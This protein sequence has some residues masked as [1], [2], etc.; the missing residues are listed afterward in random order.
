[1]DVKEETCEADIN[2]VEIM[3]VTVKE[4]DDY[5]WESV[6][7]EQE[8]LGIKD[9]DYEMVT[10]GIEEE[11]DGASVS[12]KTH[13][14]KTPGRVDLKVRSEP[15]TKRTEENSSIGIWED[16]PSPLNDSKITLQVKD[17]FLSSLAQASLQFRSQQT[18]H[19][20]NASLQDNSWPPM[21]RTTVGAITCKLQTHN[22]DSATVHQEQVK[23][24][25]GKSKSRNVN[26]SQTQQKVYQCSECGKQFTTSNGLQYHKR[27]H[28]G[29]KAY[30][31]S[32]CGKRF[33]TSSNLQD[34]RRIHTG[35]KPYCCSECGKQ[36]SERSSF[37]KHKKIH[38][39]EKPYS[40]SECGKQ[41][42]QMSALQSH[43]RIHTGEKPYSCSE[44]GKAFTT[45]HSLQD[46]RRIHTGEKPYCCSECGKEFTCK[47]SLQKH[48]RT[49][50][51]GK[52]YGCSECGKMFTSNSN[53]K[54]HRRIHTGEKP[55]GCS[56]CGKGFTTSSS[57]QTHIRVHTGEKP[58]CCS[59][60]G[61]GFV[62]SSSLLEHRRIHT[63]EKPY[64]CSECGKGFTHHSS[65]QYHRRIHTGE[66]PYSCSECG[67]QFTT[68]SSLQI[69]RRF[70]SSS[71]KNQISQESPSGFGEKEI[72]I[73]D[74]QPTNLQ[75]MRY[76]IM[77]LWTRNPEDCFQHIAESM[78]RSSEGKRRSNPL[79]VIATDPFKTVN[80]LFR[81]EHRPPTSTILNVSSLKV[82]VFSTI[83]V[84]MSQDWRMSSIVGD[85]VNRRNAIKVIKIEKKLDLTALP[86]TLR[87]QVSVDSVRM[88]SGL[89]FLRALTTSHVHP[90]RELEKVCVKEDDEAGTRLALLMNMGCCQS[91]EEK[92]A[93]WRS[94]RIDRHL[95]SESQRQ[96]REIKL[97]LLGTSNSGKSTIVKHMKIIH[98]GGFN[99]EACM[100]EKEKAAITC[101]IY[102][103]V[104]EETCEA[105][106]TS[107][108]K[109]T[110]NV[111]EEDHEWESV[112]PKQESLGIKEEE[113]KQESVIIK[114]EAEEKC[115]NNETHKYKIME[116]VKE[117]HLCYGCEDGIM[118]NLVSSQNRNSSSLESSINVKSEI[119]Q[120]DT[121]RTEDIASVRTQEDQPTPAKKSG[122]IAHKH[123][124]LGPYRNI[125]IAM[126][127]DGTCRPEAKEAGGGAQFKPQEAST[128][129]EAAG[130]YCDSRM[131]VKEKT[132]EGD[133]NTMEKMTVDIK[134]EDCKW[135]MVHPKE[136]N[137]CIK[138]EDSELGSAGMKEEA[139]VKSESLQCDAKRA[140][141]TSS[142]RTREEQP[143]TLNQSGE[144]SLEG[145]SFSPSLPTP[146]PLHFKAQM[147][148]HIENM[149]K[150]APGSE[151]LTLVSLRFIS[152]RVVK[153]K[154]TA[155]I[156]SQQQVQN[157]NPG[158]SYVC[159]EQRK[160]SECKPI[161]AE[162]S[163]TTSGGSLKK[164]PRV[165]TGEKSF[166]CTECGKKFSRSSYLKIHRRIHTGEKPYS[167]LECEKQF[168]DRRTLHNHRRIHTGEKPYSCSECDKRFFRKTDMLKH[169]SVHKKEKPY[170]CTECGKQFSRNSYLQNHKRIHTGEKPFCCLECGKQFSQRS[171]LQAHTRIHT[172][173]KP[174]KC[175]E[176][177]KQF[178]DRSY[179][180]A[181]VKLHSEK[182][183][184][185]SKCGK[186]FSEMDA[187]NTHSKVHTGE[188]PFCCTECGKQF[189]RSRHLETHT[190]IHTGEKPFCCPE[191]GKQF[192][193]KSNFNSHKRT[194]TGN[195]P[196][197][198][199]ECGKRFSQRSALQTHERTHTGQKP[200]CCSECGKKFSQMSGLQNHARIHTGEK[201]YCCSKCGRGFSQIG[202]LQR[203]T[204]IHFRGKY[205]KLKGKKKTSTKKGD[206]VMS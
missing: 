113:C 29:E 134:E 108:E 204:R 89:L 198:C 119:L 66:K 170:C 84:V 158:P 81:S 20:K 97:L 45:N 71:P 138:S 172:G 149:I 118:T 154:R 75:Q 80:P 133:I 92:E 85:I 199:P 182:P 192:S 127:D 159:Q 167:C 28:T 35:E 111:K 136:E 179:F 110:V 173:E 72:R 96:C 196:F 164:Q 51:G 153:Q 206:P 41:F 147:A 16:Q 143:S 137:M 57:L 180:Y 68:S 50:T 122:R 205:L 76:A 23:S 36:F 197:G 73:M 181:H 6:Y 54:D 166:C 125:P 3:T 157:R 12:I 141:E 145:C 104:K 194:H 150:S 115:V 18:S 90:E 83:P 165:N 59:E 131:D 189:S 176:C 175:S 202:H 38:T 114:E 129:E 117:D 40:C 168:S 106:M 62:T 55:Y 152:V 120:S 58:Y 82:N 203:H 39:G 87:A 156:A 99:L 105:D 121:K 61:K 17:G 102:M 103:D 155:A 95:R 79:K 140:E 49:H 151:S 124:W 9:E 130:I 67:K 4:E 93:A 43:T 27:I 31:C 7:S 195:K 70:H 188:K 2:T 191:C 48:K 187:L 53:L 30:C 22:S 142:P 64:C 101:N 177:R 169:S 8:N 10:V 11:A 109:R 91:S 112:H 132:C 128:K 63:G 74:V 123:C 33:T 69:H 77:S 5:E 161:P 46:H 100:E 24:I 139:E 44:C 186:R 135:E 183:Y 19:D 21:K 88:P 200:Y 201:L 47:S 32:D 146:T 107:V 148:S 65:F 56:E 190:R 126:L 60:C 193:D 160:T 185:C 42:S 1:M 178:S 162:I 184:G 116:G 98:N 34:H 94:R 174:F 26:S 15:D 37:Q 171:Y 14:H 78:P 52:P 25:Q 13:V 144:N 86:L 163:G